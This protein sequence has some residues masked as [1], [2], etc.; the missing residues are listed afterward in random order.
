MPE[1]ILLSTDRLDKWTGIGMTARQK[2]LA[3]FG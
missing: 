3:S 1:G 2:E